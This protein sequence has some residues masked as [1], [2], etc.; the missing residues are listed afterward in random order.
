MNA[1]LQKATQNGWIE[2][3]KKY[4]T[5]HD[6][7]IIAAIENGWKEVCLEVQSTDGKSGW[8]KA[9]QY[10]ERVYTRT[11]KHATGRYYHD[12]YAYER[13]NFYLIP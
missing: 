6:E 3:G 11:E 10:P 9:A 1:A 4:L 13:W 7:K 12:G 5:A 8:D 2:W